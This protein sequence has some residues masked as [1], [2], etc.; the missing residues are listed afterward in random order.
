MEILSI[1]L[2]LVVIFLLVLV[3]YALKRISQYEALLSQL[4]E[5]IDY[6][7]EQVDKLDA[8]GAFKTDDE[9]GFFWESVSH[10]SKLLNNIFEQ[11]ETNATEEK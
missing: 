3:Y 9:I 10:M 8:N 6:I 4:A 1:I 7:K 11:E 2:G 5:T